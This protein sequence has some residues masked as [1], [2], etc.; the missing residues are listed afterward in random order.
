MEPKDLT[1]QVTSSNSLSLLSRFSLKLL[2]RDLINKQVEIS[3]P[4]EKYTGILNSVQSDYVVLIESDGSL[5][6]IR[7]V[8][9]ETVIELQEGGN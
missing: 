1:N 5:V 8:K 7:T 3:T 2:L 9:I 4:F 6:F